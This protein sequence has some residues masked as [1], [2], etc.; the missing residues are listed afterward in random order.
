MNPNTL[1]YGSLL[2]SLGVDSVSSDHVSSLTG[3]QIDAVVWVQYNPTVLKGRVA[4]KREKLLSII[5][6]QNV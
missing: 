3:K 4:Q 6:E 1:C 2:S 5:N